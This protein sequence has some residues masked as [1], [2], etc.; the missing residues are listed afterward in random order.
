MLVATASLELGIDIGIV[1]LV[2]QIGS[3][4]S[5]ALPC[6]AS[7]APGTGLR[8]HAQTRGALGPRIAAPFPR[9]AS[10]PPPATNCWSARRWCA[11]SG[12]ATSTASWFPKRHSTSWR[13]RSSPPAPRRSGR[14][15]PVRPGA[16]SLS[17]SR[18][19][20]RRLRRGPRDALRRHRRPARPLRRVSA[21]RPRE[22]TSCEDGAAPAGGHHSA[23]APFPT[24]RSMAW[25]PSRKAL[26]SAPWTK[27]SRWRAW[28][29]TSS[30][31]ATPPGASAASRPQ[32]APAGGRRSR[33]AAQHSLLARRGPGAHCRA[34][35]ARRPT[36]R[37]DQRS[38]SEGPCPENSPASDARRQQS[39]GS[40]RNAASTTPAPSRRSNTSSPAAPCWA[41]CRRRRPS[42]PSA[43]STKAA[44]CSSSSTRP[45]AGASTAPGDWRCASAS[46]ARSTSSCRPRPPTTASNISLAEQ[47]SFPLA[48]VFQFLRPETVE[49]VLEQAVLASPIFTARWRWNA[50]RALAL[51]RFRGGKQ[52]PAADPAHAQPTTCWPRSSPTWRP[53]GRTSR[54]T[55]RFP[56][57]RWCSEVM[58]DCS[59]RPWTSTA[60]SRCCRQIQDGAIRTLAVDTPV[61]SQFSHEILNA[62]PYAFLDDAPLEERR[63]RAVEMRRTLPESVLEEVGTLDPEAIAQVRDEA[64]P[65]VRDA[66]ELHDALLTLIALP[67][68][69]GAGRARPGSSQRRRLAGCGG[70]RLTRRWCAQRANQRRKLDSFFYP[71]GIRRSCWNCAGRRPPLLGR[72]RTGENV[73]HH[74][75]RRAI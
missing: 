66:D 34:F 60:S 48:D 15:T 19:Q 63:A 35:R 73:Q 36:A 38:R 26:T 27:I 37:R 25:S 11:R 2:C 57:I 42:S 3:P 58:K 59:P 33:R 40:S 67:A 12:K 71:P 53:A 68:Q 13:S 8:P 61:P 9:A 39:T 51:L 46:A 43:S 4:R 30:C 70:G 45:S 49:P 18:A 16:S 54:A 21:P 7:G 56:T 52:G 29:A 23:A 6:S 24:P 41:R 64:W 32:R 22:P 74:F 20:P 75:P 10:S 5:I 55:S 1:D 69:F 14:K 28:P 44:A 62:N 47:H 50:T 72:R 65:D 17:L 31:W